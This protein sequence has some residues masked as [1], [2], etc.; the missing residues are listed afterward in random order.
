MQPERYY[1]NITTL[2][3]KYYYIFTPNRK[4]EHQLH[5]LSLEQIQQTPLL[6]SKP[7]YAKLKVIHVLPGL[8][9][10][11]TIRSY[12]LSPARITGRLP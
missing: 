5:Q 7:D 9:F 3:C 10:S 1:T 4:L 8:S 6:Y 2:L 11:F 12:P